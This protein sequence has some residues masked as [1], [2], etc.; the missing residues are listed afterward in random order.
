MFTSATLKLSADTS[1]WLVEELNKI[2]AK[3]PELKACRQI[4]EALYDCAK[5]HGVIIS[6]TGAKQ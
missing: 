6:I 2:P 5:L 4:A 3:G 1:Y